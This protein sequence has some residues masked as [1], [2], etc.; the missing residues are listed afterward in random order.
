MKKRLVGIVLVMAVIYVFPV[1][2]G[3]TINEIMADPN[4]VS[5]ALGEWL[6]L[7]NDENFAIDITNWT[8]K[9]ADTNYHQI[10]NGSVLVI[11]AKG[12]LVLGRNGNT[13]E[14]GGYAPG[15]VYNDFVLSNTE[16][17]I[18]LENS[19]G[20]EISR[21]EYINDYW[22]VYSGRS[23][24][25][26]GQ[27]LLNNPESWI[28]TSPMPENMYGDGD[29]GTPGT[30]NIIPEPSGVI[31]WIIGCFYALFSRNNFFYNLRRWK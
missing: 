28:A 29:F 18:I 13:E 2:A 31:L 26:T 8:I 25:F 17:E 5:D 30:Q 19:Y 20:V 4:A 21:V 27:G 12:F 14:N 9:D 6:E 24:A 16:D 1:Y 3:I 10:N 23:M 22:P 11:P 7:Y 15:Y